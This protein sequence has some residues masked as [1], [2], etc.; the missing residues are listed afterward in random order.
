MYLLIEC[1]VWLPA[2]YAFCYRFKPTLRFVQHPSGRK[3][4]DAANQVLVQYAPATQAQLAKLAERAKGAPAGRAAAEWA[5]LNKVSAA[6][7]PPRTRQRLRCADGRRPRLARQVLAP[8]GF[9]TKMW[10]AHLI[11]ERQKAMLT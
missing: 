9:P 5:L 3:L 10:L 2:A 7:P 4:V 8:I 11:V 1:F 6:S